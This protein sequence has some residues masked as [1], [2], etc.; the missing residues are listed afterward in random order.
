MLWAALLIL[1]ALACAVP[2]LASVGWGWDDK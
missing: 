2:A 1:L